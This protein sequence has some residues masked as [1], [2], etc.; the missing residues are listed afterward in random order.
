MIAHLASALSLRVRPGPAGCDRLEI[1]RRNLPPVTIL[2]STS[3][4]DHPSDWWSTALGWVALVSATLALH[5]VAHGALRPPPLSSTHDLANWW[6]QR[7]PLLATFAAARELLWWIGC[8][9]LLLSTLAALTTW[10]RSDGVIRNL[11]RWRLPGTRT[12]V[13]ASIGVSALGATLLSNAAPGVAQEAWARQSGRCGHTGR[14]PGAALRRPGSRG[15]PGQQCP[16]SRPNTRLRPGRRRYRGRQHPGSRPNTGLR[17]PGGGT[18]TASTSAPAVPEA[19]GPAT[20]RPTRVPGHRRQQERGQ[21]DA[22]HRFATTAH[23][24]GRPDARPGFP[25]T[26]HRRGQPDVRPGFPTTAHKSGQ[27]DARYRFPATAGNHRPG[28]SPDTGGHL[29]SGRLR[30]IAASAETLPLDP[31]P[32]LPAFTTGAPGC[33]LGRWG[34]SRPDVAGEPRGQPV[35]DRRGDAGDGVGPGS[36]RARS[37]SLLVAGGPDQPPVSPCPGGPQPAVPW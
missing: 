9:L 29:S 4:N 10:G 18:P 26:A 24:C 5:L 23:K 17:R 1:D 36:R 16:G 37:G 34:G 27:P 8:Y 15:Y 30:L 28:E 21:P 11:L 31:I 19:G 13:R 2:W 7:G 22:R 6:H 14:P 25:T 3:V 20:R 12:V 32:P 35:V 33:D